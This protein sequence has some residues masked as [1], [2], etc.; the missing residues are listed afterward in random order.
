[1][2]PR[3]L[4]RWRL[5]R[6]L[7]IQSQLLTMLLVVSVASVLVAGTI[8]YLK[9]RDSL[10]DAAFAELT[11]VREARARELTRFYEA[12]L[13]ALVIYTRGETASAAAE[14]FTEGFT[15]LAD[16]TVTADQSAE[17][18]AYYEDVFV[19]RLSAAS[20][21]EYEPSGFFPDS[22]AQRYL[23]AV[24]TAPFDDDFDAILATDDA[25]DGSSWSAAHAR[26]HDFFRELVQ[27][28]D[29]EDLL[30]LDTEGNVV[31]S[32]YKGVDLGSNVNTGPFAGTNMSEAY[33]EALASNTVDFATVTDFA[34]Y[35]PDYDEPISWA[36]SPIGTE[37]DIVGVLALQ[38]PARSINAI[39]TGDE[40]W[41]ADGLGR[42]R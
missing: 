2:G 33:D 26:Y 19:P 36:V 23:Q 38:V 12:T 31:Y 32:A 20:G 28:F 27:R 22:A 10:R 37:G 13:D 8:G 15:D 25:G 34:R 40:Q 16:S 21:V 9:G 39:M 41:S 30:L 6:R 18:E 1:M 11:A 29:Y 14:A 4:G 24:Y 3:R 35:Q 5:W 17:L 7:S 42:H